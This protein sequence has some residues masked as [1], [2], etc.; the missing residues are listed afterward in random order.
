MR[1]GLSGYRETCYTLLSQAALKYLVLK[2]SCMNEL[3]FD[4]VRHL[5]QIILKSLNPWLSS[6]PE[7]YFQI[8]R[9]MS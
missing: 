2:I 7:K 9:Q 6:G 3:L 1:T 4:K 8:Q 5:Q